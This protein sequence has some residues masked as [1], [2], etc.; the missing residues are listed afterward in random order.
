MSES[1]SGP[2]RRGLVTCPLAGLRALQGEHVMGNSKTGNGTEQVTRCSHN[3]RTK[4][5]LGGQHDLNN[6]SRFFPYLVSL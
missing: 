2:R 6:I 1:W 3:L 5:H 4:S